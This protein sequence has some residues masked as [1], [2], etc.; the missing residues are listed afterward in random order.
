MAS[1]EITETEIAKA[2]SP[3]EAARRKAVAFNVY[4]SIALN[5]EAGAQCRLEAADRLFSGGPVIQG[6]ASTGVVINVLPGAKEA[7]K[8]IKSEISNIKRNRNKIAPPKEES[9]ND[10]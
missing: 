5:A 9:E 4:E 2:L 10:D 8:K 6:S 7:A 1:L 3:E